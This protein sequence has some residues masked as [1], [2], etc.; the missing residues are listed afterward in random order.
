METEASKASIGEAKCV[1]IA[2]KA[3]EAQ[4]RRKQGRS[5]EGDLPVAG[6]GVRATGN[7]RRKFNTTANAAR[8]ASWMDQEDVPAAIVQNSNRAPSTEVLPEVAAVD[9]M[10][11]WSRTSVVTCKDVGRGR[12]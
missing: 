10:R 11:S 1:E 8:V 3:L 4:L 9:G 7:T 5:L 2:P 6:E 12:V